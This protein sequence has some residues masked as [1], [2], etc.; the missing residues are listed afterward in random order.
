MKKRYEIKST[1]IRICLHTY[2]T[3]AHILLEEAAL[4]FII[5]FS[6]PCD[7]DSLIKIAE[8]KQIRLSKTDHNELVLSFAAIQEEE[9]ETAMKCLYKLYEEV[10]EK[11][12]K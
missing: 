11:S 3:D 7:M 10:V 5:R 8:N 12:K 2:F 1:R 6:T 9:I 4:Q